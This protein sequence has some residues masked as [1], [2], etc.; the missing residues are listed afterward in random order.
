TVI[1]CLAGL[2]MYGLDTVIHQTTNRTAAVSAVSEELYLYK[3]IHHSIQQRH[4]MAKVFERIL[5]YPQ[6][7][8]V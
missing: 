3:S 2:V 8:M 4:P 7:L 1:C 5:K 6:K